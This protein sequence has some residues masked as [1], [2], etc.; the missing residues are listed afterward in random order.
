[1]HYYSQKD[2]P[3]AVINPNYK[4]PEWDQTSIMEEKSRQKYTLQNLLIENL[5]AESEETQWEFGELRLYDLMTALKRVVEEMPKVTYHEVILDEG[6]VEE[7]IDF[8]RSYL[9]TRERTSF[10]DLM[11]NT[12]KRFLVVLTFIALL[13]MCKRREIRLYQLKEFQDIWIY[14]QAAEAK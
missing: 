8:I 5:D 9:S 1:M 13:E 3:G 7:Q 2:T 12:K 11:M 6:S 14:R 10:F 4:Y